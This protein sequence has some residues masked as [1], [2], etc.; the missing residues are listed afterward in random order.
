MDQG[1]HISFRLLSNYWF[2]KA[3]ADRLERDY[4]IAVSKVERR[5]QWDK[6]KVARDFSPRF[7]TMENWGMSLR[8]EAEAEVGQDLEQHQVD[9]NTGEV[10]LPGYASP[11]IDPVAFRQYVDPT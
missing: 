3:Q 9:L 5:Y 2:Y 1:P 8:K 4:K 7:R 10:K 11:P 6:L